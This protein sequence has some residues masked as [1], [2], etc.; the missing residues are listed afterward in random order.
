MAAKIFDLYVGWFEK[1]NKHY[2]SKQLEEELSGLYPGVNIEK[3]IKDY[4]IKKIESAVKLGIATVLIVLLYLCKHLLSTELEDG[5]YLER[6]PEGEGDREIVLDAQIEDEMIED[7]MITLGEKEMSEEEK[8]KLLQ[9]V[10][11]HLE[12]II[13]GENESLEQVTRPL[14]LLTEW[15]DTEV[16]IEWTSNNYGVL[17]EDGTFGTEE[18]PKQGIQVEIT[19]YIYLNEMQREKKIT[20]MVYPKEK[21]AEDEVRDNLI[22]MVS[23]K[24]KES[25]EKEY[26]ELP[27]VLDGKQ[28]GWQEEKK[29]FFLIL[30]L[31]P[32]IAVFAV[33]WGKD[34]DI[35]TQYK[36]RNRQLLME[37]SEFVS[38]L[39]LLIGAGMS[40]RNAFIRLAFDYQKRKVAG[41]KKR[42]VY[43]EVMMMVRKL[44]NG[45][46]EADAYDYFAKRCNLMCYRKLVSIILQNQR[47]GTEGLKDSL[48][49][50]TRN[51]FEERKQEAVRLGEE[52]GTKLL[53]PM[54]MMMGVVL[55]IIVIPAYFSFGGI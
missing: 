49:T 37:Y 50:E 11:T 34:R 30:V 3:Q 16:Y 55:M 53:L 22:D 24:E 31:F 4:Y 33:I 38:K 9:E 35:H 47:K 32:V 42:F 45:A 8:E 20:V 25:R 2:Y 14:N 46:S 27:E 29:D 5:K 39:Q 7:V 10:E 13:K 23:Q 52:A 54:M 40:V 41:G 19:A 17:Q 15:E 44:E 1:K 21:S 43:E 48:L 6:N 12:E 51:A 18:I 26:L 28:I 36:E